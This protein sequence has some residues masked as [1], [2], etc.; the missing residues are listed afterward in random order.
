[1]RPLTVVL[2]ASLIGAALPVAAQD[3]G[4]VKIGEATKRTS[5]TL[6]AMNIGDVACYLTLK[7]E[8]GAVFE[9]MATFEIC[10]KPALLGK[11]VAL[12]YVLGK[13][14]AAEC[15]GDV[16]CKKT[17]TVALVSAARVIET[18]AG[19]RPAAPQ[20]SFCTPTEVV[21]FSCRT[22]TGM[23]SVCASQDAGLNKGYLQYRFG[24]HDSGEPLEITLPEGRIAP[25]KAAA[26]E[27]VSFSG[28]GGT[29]LR[30]TKAAVTYT[31]YSGIGNWG[32]KGEKRT[33]EGLVVERAGKPVAS[34]KCLELTTSLLGPD[35]FEKVGINPGGQ[36]F[37]FPD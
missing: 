4:T 20:P 6:T 34:L 11:R 2:I 23:V 37:D 15:A 10:E 18:A 17:R 31:V 33:K 32:P 22:G 29:W 5:G 21:V 13:V 14:I 30:F 9:E 12:T 8:R 25:A 36:S 7:D 1:M 24:K 35:W 19:A 27:V 28:G 3:S 26:G 16:G